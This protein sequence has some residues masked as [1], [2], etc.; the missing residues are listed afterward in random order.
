M[1]LM[2]ADWPPSKYTRDVYISPA[3]ESERG[4]YNGIGEA[5]RVSESETPAGKGCSF[6]SAS[7][8]RYF[9]FACCKGHW[10][11]GDESE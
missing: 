11:F 1:R 9:V 3:A 4:V 8:S 6:E 7:F 2:L 5:E 10:F